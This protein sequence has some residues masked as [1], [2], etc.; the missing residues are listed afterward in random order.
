VGRSSIEVAS[1]GHS[2][3]VAEQAGDDRRGSRRISGQEP[4]TSTVV[5]EIG[6]AR[7]EQLCAVRLQAVDMARSHLLVRIGS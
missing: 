3:V 4:A 5:G 1:V 7:G 6:V 2:S